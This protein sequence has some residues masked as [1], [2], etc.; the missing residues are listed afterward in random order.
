MDH[1]HSENVQYPW[2]F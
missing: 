1:T 2:L